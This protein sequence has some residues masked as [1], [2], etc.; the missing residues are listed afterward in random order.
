MGE[1]LELTL[2]PTG[3]PTPPSGVASPQEPA[4]VDG[5][6]GVCSGYRTVSLRGARARGARASESPSGK[7][8]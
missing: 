4:W 6:V 1:S 7:N 2:S 5:W 3:E 8:G